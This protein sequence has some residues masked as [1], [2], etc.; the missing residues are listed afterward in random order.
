MQ[1]RV[2]WLLHFWRVDCYVNRIL[3]V[4]KR[5]AGVSKSNNLCWP[6]ALERTNNNNNAKNP[7]LFLCLLLF[8]DLTEAWHM[9][10]LMFSHMPAAGLIKY[11][12]ALHQIFSKSVVLDAAPASSTLQQPGLFGWPHGRTGSRSIP[13]RRER[14][15]LVLGEGCRAPVAAPAGNTCLSASLMLFSWRYRK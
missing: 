1:T 11:W 4:C 13:P 2:F 5:V 8:P 7:P 10:L 9:L 15:A 3:P 6:V 14:A 12:D